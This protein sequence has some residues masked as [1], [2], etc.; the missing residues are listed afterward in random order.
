[1][2]LD[3]G[4]RF[5]S[6]QLKVRQVEKKINIF[7]ILILYRQNKRQKKKI[8]NKKQSRALRAAPWPTKRLETL[9]QSK[10]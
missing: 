7:K 3:S 5:V 2:W 10:T 8:K 1:M 9:N 6:T 4:V